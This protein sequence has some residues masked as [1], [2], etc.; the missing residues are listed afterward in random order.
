M[1]VRMR[2]RSCQGSGCPD[3]EKEGTTWLCWAFVT[4]FFQAFP[5]PNA[6][7]AFRLE[8]NLT[9]V[10][11]ATRGE[12]LNHVIALQFHQFVEELMESGQLSAKEDGGVVGRV[13]KI[14][15]ITNVH[16][17]TLMVW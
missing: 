6:V 13:T 3:V 5:P 11:K 17:G 2:K 7:S 1:V 16:S 15:L 8:S 12:R 9:K 4:K 14:I 10:G